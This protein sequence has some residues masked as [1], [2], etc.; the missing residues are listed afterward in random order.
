MQCRV[1]GLIVLLVLVGCASRGAGRHRAGAGAGLE[2][3]PRSVWKA[4]PARG[5][6]SDSATG[7]V[8][9]GRVFR[10]T[11]HHSGEP[12][13]MAVTGVAEV[14]ERLRGYQR[15]HQ[16]GNGWADV[17]YHYLVDPTG[18]V[19]EGREIRWKG[20]HAGNAAANEG[21]VGVCVLGNFD[22][23]ELRPG[24]MQGLERLLVWLRA[25]YGFARGE[26]YTHD[27]LRRRY[28]VGPTACPGRRLTQ[29]VERY[30][31]AAR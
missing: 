26:V 25:K 2:V 23:E 1:L 28:G 21:N 22:V 12:D 20:A 24:Q 18:R 3:L 11:V 15:H 16:Q 6:G 13:G 31:G 19:W 27:E 17:G 7:L 5:D 10:A 29:W 14:A 4:Q 9:M 30:R 8:P